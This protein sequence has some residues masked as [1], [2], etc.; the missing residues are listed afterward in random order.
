MYAVTTVLA[1]GHSILFLNH[2]RRTA[3]AVLH[4]LAIENTV[5]QRIPVERLGTLNS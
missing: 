5:N 1:T 2:C 4:C 3:L